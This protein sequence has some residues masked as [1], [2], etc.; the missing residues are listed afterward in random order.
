MSDELLPPKV[1]DFVIA[2]WRKD[3]SYDYASNG[4]EVMAVNEKGIWTKSTFHGGIQFFSFE[5]YRFWLDPYYRRFD[6]VNRYNSGYY[7]SRGHRE[8]Y[9]ECPYC[10]AEAGQPCVVI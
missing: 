6:F 5:R 3:L 10:C 4:N 9:P 7:I 1:G 2:H 8:P